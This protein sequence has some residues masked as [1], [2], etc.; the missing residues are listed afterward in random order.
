[1]IVYVAGPMTGLAWD[2]AF[3]H[4]HERA[5][6]IEALGFR[7]LH[8]MIGKAKRS[9]IS[10]VIEPSGYDDPVSNDHAVVARDRWMVAQADIVFVDLTH[11]HKPSLGTLGELAWASTQPKTLS[12]VTGWET[13][14]TLWGDGPPPRTGMDHA[15]V[16]GLAG[17]AF[18]YIHDAINH[19]S[20]LAFALGLECP[21]CSCLPRGV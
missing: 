8:P 17:L 15:F 19:L 18:P 4:F 5:R 14:P 12:I 11:A 16:H 2:E 9:V 3:E 21:S 7:V 1:M 20:E 10:D 6:E 13:G